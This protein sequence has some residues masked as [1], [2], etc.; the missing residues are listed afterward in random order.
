MRYTGPVRM[1]KPGE[2]WRHYKGGPDSL[3]VIIGTGYHTETND[4]V[5]VYQAYSWSLALPPTLFVRP[6]SVFLGTT[7]EHKPRFEFERRAPEPPIPA[8]HD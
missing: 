1:P 4:A 6:L 7:D 8:T 5:V 3:Y 2:G